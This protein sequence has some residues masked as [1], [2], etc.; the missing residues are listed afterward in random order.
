M[1]K[2]EIKKKI[3]EI[4][5]LI[6]ILRDGEHRCIFIANQSI[7]MFTDKILKLELELNKK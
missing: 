3:L 4:K 5:A 2:A 1:N 6:D 7:D